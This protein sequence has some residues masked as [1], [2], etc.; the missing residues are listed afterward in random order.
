MGLARLVP[1][2]ETYR[3][4]A[5]YPFGR[6]F[7]NHARTQV[8][9]HQYD[10]QI[11]FGLDRGNTR[12]TLQSVNNVGPRV[13]RIDGAWKAHIQKGQQEQLTGLHSLGQTDGGN[14]SSRKMK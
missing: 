2:G 1:V 13:D 9:T 10:G 12:V 5:F 7:P 6:T 8:L 14:G 11:D 4:Y 3:D